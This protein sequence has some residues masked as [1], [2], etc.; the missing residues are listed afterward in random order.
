MAFGGYE[1]YVPLFAYSALRALPGVR[2]L[3]HLQPRCLPSH[4]GHLVEGA[5]QRDGSIEFE[6]G[7]LSDVT[8][9]WHGGAIAGGTPKLARWIT[10]QGFFSGRRY[11]LFLDVDF[12][13]SSRASELLRGQIE[14]LGTMELPFLNWERDCRS[15]LR[16]SYHLVD[17]KPYFEAVSSSVSDLSNQSESHRHLYAKLSEERARTTGGQARIVRDEQVLHWICRQHFALELLPE[18]APELPGIHIG[19]GR[20]G[21]RGRSRLDVD[22]DLQLS[23]D[24]TELHETAGRDELLQALIQADPESN[25]INLFLSA[26]LI[27]PGTSNTA[28][29]RHALARWRDMALATALGPLIRRDAPARILGRLGSRRSLRRAPAD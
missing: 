8:Q 21:A 22:T 10:S 6:F 16:G 7:H 9:E 25:L 20:G 23:R 26:G 1:H 28:R 24:I 12:V 13:F 3:V 14:Q 4:L 17:V 19:L 15:R 29:F 2:V 11:A 27:P 18:D 5:R